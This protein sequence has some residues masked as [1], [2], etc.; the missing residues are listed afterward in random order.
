MGAGE[1]TAAQQQANQRF[2]EV[3]AKIRND[4]SRD[5]VDD[6]LAAL[7]NVT[8]LS[9]VN[10]SDQGV[11]VYVTH[12]GADATPLVPVFTSLDDYRAFETVIPPRFR[13]S[14]MSSVT[15]CQMVVACFPPSATLA[16]DPAKPGFLRVPPD[17]IR[18]IAS[19]EW[20]P[21]N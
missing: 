19:A 2:A 16:I 20:Q 10:E 7:A 6:Y 12:F 4:V 5:T 17:L 13:A 11:E 21:F 14:L 9:P 8:F 3:A 15:M 18:A 1:L